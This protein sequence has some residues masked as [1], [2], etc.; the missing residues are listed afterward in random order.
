MTVFFAHVTISA[1]VWM[2]TSTGRRPGDD[3]PGA[4]IAFP[5][6]A[7]RIRRSAEP[8][9]CC[10]RFYQSS[11]ETRL[12]FLS[13]NLTAHSESFMTKFQEIQSFLPS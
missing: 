12:P 9:S 10:L 5:V 4:R 13:K 6:F 1:H 3:R 11:R 8:R 2:E 7:L